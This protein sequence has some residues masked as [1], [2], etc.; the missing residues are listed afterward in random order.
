MVNIILAN[1]ED[2]SIV[3]LRL[4]KQ[5][6]GERFLITEIKRRMYGEIDIRTVTHASIIKVTRAFRK[7]GYKVIFC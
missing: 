6:N 3:R 2:G 4:V 7:Q 5:E 1:P